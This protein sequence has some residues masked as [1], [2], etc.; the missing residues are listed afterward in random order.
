MMTGGHRH[1]CHWGWLLWSLPLDDAGEGVVIVIVSIGGHI[2]DI[3]GGVVIV[4]VLVVAINT[5]GGRGVVKW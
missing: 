3:D 1:C 2:N 5:G 4:V